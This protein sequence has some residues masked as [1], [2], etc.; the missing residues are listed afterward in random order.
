MDDQR[1][2]SRAGDAASAG[3]SDSSRAREHASAFAGAARL[4]DALHRL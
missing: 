3:A 1:A 2:R 4:R